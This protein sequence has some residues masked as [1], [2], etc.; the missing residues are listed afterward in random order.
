MKMISV[1]IPVYNVEEYLHVC[2]NSVLKQT[3]QDFEIIC[4]D[5]ASTDS[6]L[7]IL[8]YFSKKD[9]RIRIL[10]NER[11]IGLGPTRNKGMEVAEG[12]YILFLDSDDWYSL[13]TLETL[14]DA[15][16]KNEL[17]VLMFK[18]IV[19]YEESRDFG[20][21]QY[22]DMDFLNEF[23]NKIFNHW[24]LDKTRIFQIPIGACNKLYLKSFLDKNSIRFTNNN[25]IHED[26]PFSC[27]VLIHADKISVINKYFYNRRRR[28]GSITNLNNERLFD[29]I[30]IVY[31]ILDVFLEDM[32]I[33]EYYKK[34]VLYYIFVSVLNGKYNQIEEKYKDKFFEEIQ[35][36]YRYFVKEY[37]LYKDIL[38]NVDESVLSRFKFEDIVDGLL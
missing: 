17:D 23:E 31:L 24:D 18:N 7:D 2:I 13:D 5:D 10:K 30:G 29:N 8:E 4:I 37:H 38:E 20:M 26:N 12:K 14:V 6:S 21:E 9:S 28:P 32:Q 16:E 15:M 11:N 25:Y 33:Y 27:K 22:Y 3:Y 34:Q 19:Y 1:I 35:G 36:V